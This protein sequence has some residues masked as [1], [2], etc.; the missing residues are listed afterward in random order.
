[1]PNNGEIKVVFPD[2]MKVASPE[3]DS[4]KAASEHISNWLHHDFREIIKPLQVLNELE[5]MLSHFKKEMVEQFGILFTSQIESQVV[6][7]QASIRAN[8]QKVKL[9]EDQ[10]SKK[11][12]QFREAKG[13]IVARY[14]KIAE[15]LVG[16]HAKYLKQLDSLAYEIVDKIYPDQIQEGFSFASLPAQKYLA[17]HVVESA[18]TRSSALN[19]SY[20][21]AK[22]IMSEFLKKRDSFIGDIELGVTDKLE[23]GEYYLPLWHIEVEDRETGVKHIELYFDWEIDGNASPISSA[24]GE[25]LREIGTDLIKNA[26]FGELADADKLEL[27]NLL[28]KDHDTPED[29]VKR[30]VTDNPRIGMTE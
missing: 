20:N 10:I 11:E 8:E 22:E 19:D 30:L 14:E 4:I 28:I 7:R 18:L 23:A 12:I 29:E 13:R 9:I 25:I 1:M 16:E 26:S 24:Q 15:Q 2:K 3:I 5:D 27:V 6:S 21:K 17:A